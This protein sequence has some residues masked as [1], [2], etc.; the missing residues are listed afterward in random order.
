MVMFLNCKFGLCFCFLFFLLNFTGE[1][2]QDNV[3]AATI[4]VRP[5]DVFGIF[6]FFLE[7]C[8]VL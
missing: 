4:V 1:A 8:L 6:H 2:T 5:S 7:F 3:F